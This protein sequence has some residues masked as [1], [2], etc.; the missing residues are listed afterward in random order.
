MT[1]PLTLE[2]PEQSNA[3][4]RLED[5]PAHLMRRATDVAGVSRD[6]VMK[7]AITIQGR[8]YVKVE[9][10]QAI[11]IAHGCVASSR[12]VERVDSGFR[13]I[14][15]VR[16]INDGTVLATAEGFV[17]DDEVKTWGQRPEYAKRAMAQTR[18]ISRACRSAF[19]H[20]VVLIDS[21]LSTTPAEEVPDEG[22]SQPARTPK[23]APRATQPTKQ[24]TPVP[25]AG[26]PFKSKEQLIKLL[27][28]NREAAETILREEG[29]LLDTETLEDWPDGKLPIN[30]DQLNSF[31]QAVQEEA[32][33]PGG[34]DGSAEDYTIHGS[35]EPWRKMGTPFAVGGIPAGTPFGDLPR[36]KLWWWCQKWVPK[37]YNGK[38]KESDTL[39]RVALDGVDE[40]YFNDKRQQEA[41]QDGFGTAVTVDPT[42][43]V[44]F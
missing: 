37:P 10:W 2:Q 1:E 34:G 41:P 11:A 40:K 3:L 18:A 23:A 29:V 14:G 22:F 13:A 9:G 35:D 20:V 33:N 38:I 36:N 8:K 26:K 24:A 30:A 17:G 25:T 27:E 32:D 42:D 19:A 6:I 21:N 15:E 43:D 12:D 5:N 7:T 16:R 4:I 31:L 28:R 39:L 44:P